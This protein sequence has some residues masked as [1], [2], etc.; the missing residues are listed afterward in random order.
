M[1][2]ILLFLSAALLSSCSFGQKTNSNNKNNNQMKAV[3]H[4]ADSRGH[5]NHGE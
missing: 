2:K 5:A 4:K 3:Y 1:R